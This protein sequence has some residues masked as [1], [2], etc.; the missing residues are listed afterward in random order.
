MEGIGRFCDWKRINAMHLD[1]NVLTCPFSKKKEWLTF[2]LDYCLFV[3][4]TKK[5]Y[6]WLINYRPPSVE[7][8]LIFIIPGQS[9]N[10]LPQCQKKNRQQLFTSKK[11]SK[12]LNIPT[13]VV[14]PTPPYIFFLSLLL[15]LMKVVNIHVICCFASHTSSWWPIVSFPNMASSKN[16]PNSYL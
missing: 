9:N 3:L 12:L 6:S 4:L 7:H 5:E 8:R 13:N 16:R 14:P 10:Y 15:K 1:M 11:K 2:N